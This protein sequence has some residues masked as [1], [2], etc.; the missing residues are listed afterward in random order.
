MQCINATKTIAKTLTANSN[1]GFTTANI[2]SAFC[3]GVLLE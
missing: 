3:P 1:Y 2:P